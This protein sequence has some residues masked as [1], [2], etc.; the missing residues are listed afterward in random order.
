[1]KKECQTCEW[2][3]YDENRPKDNPCVDCKNYEFY[4]PDKRKIEILKEKQ[5]RLDR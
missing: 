2:R 5:P 4:K 3:Y 1:M